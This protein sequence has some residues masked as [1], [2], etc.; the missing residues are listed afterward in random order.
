M[1]NSATFNGQ[2]FNSVSLFALNM[3]VN[4]IMSRPITLGVASN[5]IALSTKRED[6]ILG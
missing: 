5:V 6:V 2:P 1:F 4:V 3:V